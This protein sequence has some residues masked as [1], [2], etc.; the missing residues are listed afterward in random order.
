MVFKYPYFF[1][2]ILLVKVFMQHLNKNILII[3]DLENKYLF[4]FCLS[5][6]ECTYKETILQI[7]NALKIKH[8]DVLLL[9]CEISCTADE[10]MTLKYVT[11]HYSNITTIA[12]LKKTEVKLS[13][14]L[15]KIGI[16][17]ILYIDELGEL[18]SMINKTNNAKV[19]LSKLKISLNNLS[20]LLQ[21]ILLFMEN[22]YLN[23]F[24]ITDIA[25]DF[26]IS[27]CT[28]SR[29]FQKYKIC[30]PKQLLRQFKVVHSME[31][32]QTTD[33]KIKEIANLSG[34]TNEQRYIESFTKVFKT[35]P[36]MYR[37]KLGTIKN[38]KISDQENVM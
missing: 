29:I 5:S 11:K 10:I 32:L 17:E 20:P 21:K 12:I 36:S 38:M 9:Y 28:I 31:L 25:N 22:N 13:H 8:F 37:I 2:I 1:D 26:G 35:S 7:R 14:F 34:F 3:C 24:T 33:L 6:F 18:S 23:I 19:T 30:S 27:E 15:G 4:K 16:K